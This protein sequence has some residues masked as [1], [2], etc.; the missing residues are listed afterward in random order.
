MFVEYTCMLEIAFDNL[1][2]A[3]NS[4][5]NGFSADITPFVLSTNTLVRKFIFAWEET[6]KSQAT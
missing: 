2:Q 3:V 1:Y 4:R 6:A 5:F